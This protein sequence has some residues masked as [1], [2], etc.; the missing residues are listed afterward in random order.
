MTQNKID[1]QDLIPEIK[2]FAP[3]TVKDVNYEYPGYIGIYFTD[4]HDISFGDSLSDDTGYTWQEA[5]EGLE[6][7]N[8][9]FKELP[10]AE[11][12]AIEL[13][14]QYQQ[15][16]MDDI[17]FDM[18]LV[19]RILTKRGLKSYVENTGGGCATIYCGT[20]DADGYYPVAAGPGVVSRIGFPFSIGHAE[21]FCWGS[22]K[23]EDD[24]VTY[25]GIADEKVIAE[26]IWLFYCAKIGATYHGI[27]KVEC[28]EC[29]HTT[30]DIGD[31]EL[32]NDLD[33]LCPN[34]LHR[35]TKWH[36]ID[37]SFV[38][39]HNEFDLDARVWY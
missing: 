3:E 11:D 22:D 37:G 17:E 12:I 15:T 31:M 38:E 10:T 16:K 36:Q 33:D 26:K 19:A 14:T 32:R 18:S 13:W 9:F 7:D 39:T 28:M 24:C 1:V 35:D 4:G 6:V 29:G 2:K 21:D 5:I 30:T 23:D 8:G 27:T 34:C 20:A 25:D